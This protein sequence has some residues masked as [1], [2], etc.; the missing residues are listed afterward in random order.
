[1]SE[2]E[3]RACRCISSSSSPRSQLKPLIVVKLMVLTGAQS[4][5]LFAVVAFAFALEIL[6]FQS[7]WRGLLHGS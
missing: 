7:M 3:T 2:L 4:L 5:R 6:E 1:M